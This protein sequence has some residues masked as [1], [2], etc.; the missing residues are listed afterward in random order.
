[1]GKES[2]NEWR[3]IYIYIIYTYICIKM[4]HFPI[5]LKLT[6]HDKSTILQ[7]KINIKL[8]YYPED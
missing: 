2:E 1:M 5:H 3:Y 4:N 7:Y 8:K 6:Q